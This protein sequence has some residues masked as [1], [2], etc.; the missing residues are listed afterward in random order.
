[1]FSAPCS[2]TTLI[3]RGHKSW[4]DYVEK[5]QRKIAE[6]EDNEVGSLEDLHILKTPVNLD[7]GGSVDV[8]DIITAGSDRHDVTHTDLRSAANQQSF[9]VFCESYDFCSEKNN[10][11]AKSLMAKLR[12]VKAQ[13][14]ELI[15]FN[16]QSGYHC[17][18]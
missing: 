8:E 14:P 15:S 2:T 18:S 1:M 3:K 16:C 10:K 4:C 5:V 13:A 6:V 17:E 7:L 11:L 12:K 9:L